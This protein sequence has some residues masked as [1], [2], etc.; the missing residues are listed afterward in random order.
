MHTN[1]GNI[2]GPAGAKKL[3]VACAVLPHLEALLLNSEAATPR[4]ATQ[5]AHV[6]VLAVGLT[7]Q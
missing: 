1:T 6:V 2:L 3:A 4:H 7:T 5:A